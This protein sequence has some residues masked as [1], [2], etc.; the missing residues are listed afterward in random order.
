MTSRQV[1][2]DDTEILAIAKILSDGKPHKA[3]DLAVRLGTSEK[4]IRRYLHF[5]REE[6]QLPIKSGNTG[7]LVRKQIQKRAD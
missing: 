2:E 1:A 4:N 6:M 3:G 5:M 7:F